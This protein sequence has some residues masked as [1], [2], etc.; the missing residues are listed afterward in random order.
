VATEECRAAMA[1]V[2]MVDGSHTVAV[3]QRPAMEACLYMVVMA[4]VMTQLEEV[5]ACLEA[6]AV[7]SVQ[8]MRI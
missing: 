5:M 8:S 3:T 7:V 6:M 2:D 4:A 1:T